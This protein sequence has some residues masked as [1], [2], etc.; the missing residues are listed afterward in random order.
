MYGMIIWDLF[1]KTINNFYMTQLRFHTLFVH[2]FGSQL[3]K[4]GSSDSLDRPNQ[5]CTFSRMGQN[6]YDIKQQIAVHYKK[7][8][9]S[10]FCN[11]ISCFIFINI[12]DTSL[13]TS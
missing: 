1:N 3:P 8:Q 10:C 13:Q 7:N 6:I 11:N 9:P 4:N 2:H 12:D 5:W